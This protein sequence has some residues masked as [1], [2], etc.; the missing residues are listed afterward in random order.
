MPLTPIP[1]AV[2]RFKAG[3]FIIIVDDEDRENEG[4]LVIA[5]E[6]ITPQAIAFMARHASGLICVPMLGSDLGRLGLPLMVPPDRNGTQFGT[7]FTVS[8]EARTGVTTG[9]SAYDRTRTIQVLTDPASVAGDIVQPGHVFPLRCHPGGVLAR[10]GQTEAS[11]EMARLAGLQ[12]AA[13]ICE[14]MDDDGGM[15]RMPSLV[16]FSAQHNI[17]IISIAD[18]TGY[19]LDRRE[20]MN[21]V[22]PPIPVTPVVERMVKTTLPTRAG[23]FSISAYR[24][25]DDAQ[26]AEPHLALQTGDISSP[27]P[28]LVR[29]HSEC[30]TGDVFGSARCDCGEQ[31]EIALDQNGRHGRGIV[32]YLR[33]EG[34]GIGLVNKLR[35]YALQDEGLDTVE[36]NLELGFPADLRTYGVAAAMLRDLGVRR[37]RLLTNNP[38]KLDGLQRHGIEIVE[39][40][41]LTVAPGAGNTR[42]LA[43][44]QAKLGHLLGG[45]L[46]H[47]ADS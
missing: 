23:A 22:A 1:E 20:V 8:V 13:V 27:E 34:R 19:L 43:T 16:R 2:T 14:I 45:D 10:R 39:R 46:A 31:L 7:A 18:L 4:D 47:V 35:A 3:G 6:A 41:P 28:V 42:Y 12:P 33:Q 38:R 32:L 40:V 5:A 15:A 37:I 26:D 44:K 36:A 11:V 24:A 21:I 30:L 17:P 29:L 25:V 9:I